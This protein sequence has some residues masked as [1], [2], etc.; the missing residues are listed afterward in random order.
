MKN[1]KKPNITFKSLLQ[2]IKD[3]EER[4]KYFDYLSDEGKRLEIAWDQLQ[5]IQRRKVKA[6]G[7][8][9]GYWN[10]G[11]KFKTRSLTSK[12]LQEHLLKIEKCE[13][14]ARGRIM[15][16][17]IRL[18]NHISGD[19]VD[20]IKG[21]NDNLKGF[22][23]HDMRIIEEEYERSDYDHPYESGTTEKLM[24]IL[25]NILVN[26][27]FNILDQTDYLI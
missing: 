5:L 15:M 19:D 9:I 22:S 24:N 26:G 12:E 13:V 27:N 4:N 21:C 14:C 8:Q 2:P 6:I 11:L 17:Q 23:I 16:S 7:N 3:I 25:C 18:G 1:L 20:R 10:D